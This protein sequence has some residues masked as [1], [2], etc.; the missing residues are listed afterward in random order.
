MVVFDDIINFMKMKK[1]N[2][3]DILKYFSLIF[4]CL[5]L[6]QAEIGGLSPFLFAFLFACVYVGL[7]E[8]FVSVLVLFCGTISDF[9]LENFLTALTVVFVALLVFYIHKFSK[10]RIHFLTIFV[11]YIISCVTYFYYHIHNISHV[12]L[13][14]LLGLVCVFVYITVTQVMLLRKNCF[15]LTLDESICFLFAIASLG[16]GLSFVNVFGLSLSRFF[17]CLT[18]LICVSIGSPSLTYAIVLAFSFGCSL[19]DFNLNCL[20]EFMVLA[21]LAG[22][23]SMPNK[24][25]TCF[26]VLIA[27]VVVQYCFITENFNIF[28][29]LA[30]ILC[31]ILIFLL[32]PKKLSY[33]LADF[34]YVKK[35]EITSRNVINTTRKNIKKRMVELSNIFMEMK[36]IHLGMTKKELTKEELVA[37]LIREITCSCCKDCLDKNRCTRS[38]GTDNKSNL[39]L[40]VEI[41]I[42][43]G[44]ITLLDVPSGITGRCVKVNNLIGL[45]NRIIDEYKQYK[46]IMADINNVKILM[47]D[48]M[49][50]VSRLLLDVGDEIDTNVRFDVARE[51]KIIS[52]LLGL[53]IYCKEVLL[54]TE[55]SDD[56]SAVLVVDSENSYNPMIEKVLTETLKVPMQIT[57][58]TPLD[59]LGFNSIQ[60]RKKSKYDC[61]FGLASCNKAGN[62]EC[63]DCHSIIRLGGNKFL[64]ALCDGMGAGNSAHKMS[65]MTLGLIENFYK[66]GFD[67]DIVLESVNKLLSINNQ[68]MYSTLDV[69]L[70][71]LEKEIADFVKVGA[72][73]GFIKRENNMEMVEGGSLP[74]GALETITPAI[75]KTTISTR[76]IIILVTDGIVDSFKTNESL[77]EFVGGI[78]TNNPQVIAESIL[79]EALS[80]SAMSAKDDMT[81]LVAR[82]YLKT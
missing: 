46:N 19:K 26:M 12:I 32:L 65:A 1:L 78:A 30:P 38:L 58:I 2:T 73:I 63:G 54:Y 67:N 74:I 29:N 18:L 43:K 33:S 55:K 39:E 17:V 42:S 49:G 37:M 69:C 60:L 31:A 21:M 27:D 66:A 53:N 52:R 36:Q 75:Y 8:K 76:D 14:L 6:S 70:L 24:F 71:D 47:A 7:N 3:Y 59:E 56:I 25:K 61:V 77:L 57:K 45:V 35:S 72:P 34:V 68:E 50:A 13:F 44:K 41:A 9:S 51:N 15:K 16:L 81:V 4:V 5:V 28:L 48:Q 11:S 20:A 79:N 82:T 80:L 23:F 10:Q 40:M 22:V 62:Q 64:L